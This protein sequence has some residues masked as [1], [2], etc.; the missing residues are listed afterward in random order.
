MAHNDGS[1]A[2]GCISRSTQYARCARRRAGSYLPL[3]PITSSPI[4]VTNNCSGVVNSK[5]YVQ[6]TIVDLRPK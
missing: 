3:L 2:A 1:V 5:V 4:E 6:H